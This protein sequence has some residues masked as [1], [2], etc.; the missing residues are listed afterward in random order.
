MTEPEH[1][2]VSRAEAEKWL[3]GGPGL[4]FVDNLAHTVITLHDQTERATRLEAT[5]RE[6]LRASHMPEPT[7]EKMVNPS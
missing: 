1:R 5:L 2:V 3:A 7:I 4:A 6:V